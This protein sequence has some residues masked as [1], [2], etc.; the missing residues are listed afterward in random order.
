[1]EGSLKN[2]T[3]KL[4]ETINIISKS[5]KSSY[6]AFEYANNQ[7]TEKETLLC[8][9]IIFNIIKD[10]EVSWNNPNQRLERILQRKLQMSAERDWQGYQRMEMYPMFMFW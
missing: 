8:Y 5:I 2:S 3:R 10:N 9:I 1:M 4:L 6:K 7:Y